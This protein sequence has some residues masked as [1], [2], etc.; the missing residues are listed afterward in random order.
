MKNKLK[1]SNL[2]FFFVVLYCTIPN[3]IKITSIPL[4]YV[5]SAISI[6]LI[7]FYKGNVILIKKGIRFFVFINL[8][9]LIPMLYHKEYLNIF[10]S[11]VTN[12]ALV[13]LLFVFIDTK[14]K[15]ITLINYII[16]GAFA[17]EVLSLFEFVFEINVFE[18]LA[19]DYEFI[20]NVN[21]YRFGF[22]RIS[23]SF[24]NSINYCIFL[25]FVSILIMYKSNIKDSIIKYSKFDRFVY[26]LTLLCSVM[27]MSR[28]VLLVMMGLNLLLYIVATDVKRKLRSTLKII[29]IAIV[30]ICV[31]YLIGID[32]LGILMNLLYMIFSLF[33][34]NVQLKIANTFGTNVQAVG[35][36]LDLFN[37]VIQELQ[38]FEMLGKGI[39]TQFSH[40]VNELGHKKTSIENDYLLRLFRYGY[41]GLTTYIVMLLNC[42]GVQLRKIKIKRMNERFSFVFIMFLITIGYIVVMFTVSAGEELKLYYVL[43]VM[44]FSYVYNLKREDVNLER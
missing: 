38:G 36:R 20:K 34:I 4:N 31:T 19:T 15:F 5:F 10:T 13:V 43:I 33:S 16:I 29:T 2:I 25:F 12:V 42:V 1:L 35:N 8:V 6:I 22:L 40:I 39:Y 44:M 21:N 3:Y 27:T 23:S 7:I 26:F 30:I 18:L 14:Q 17:L 28:G 32:V 37:W 11:L 9:M 24:Y 41:V